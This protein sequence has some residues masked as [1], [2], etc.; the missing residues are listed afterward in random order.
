MANR[1]EMD[2]FQKQNFLR[3]NHEELENPNRSI[4][5]RNIESIIKNSQETKAQDQ[6]TSLF[7][8]TKQLKKI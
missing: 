8:F 5:I 4:T 2:N 7:N 6:M 1:E 3:L